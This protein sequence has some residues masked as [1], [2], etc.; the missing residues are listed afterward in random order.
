MVINIRGTSGSGKSWVM[1]R[2]LEEFPNRYEPGLQSTIL[3]DRILLIGPYYTSS[4][5]VGVD[6]MLHFMTLD[7]IHAMAVQKMMPSPG[8]FEGKAEQF[9]HVM[10]EGL[11]VSN[12]YERYRKMAA[13]VDLRWVFLNTP[14]DVC[15]RQVEKRRQ[16]RGERRPFKPENTITKWNSAQ[17]QVDKARSDGMQVWS[18]SSNEAVDL[19]TGW[20]R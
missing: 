4:G 3:D 6:Y 18:V 14:L 19:V 8:V 9:D 13:E 17:R 2:L 15:L 7:H 16:E 1:R 11:I 20:L 12:V 10:F 5:A